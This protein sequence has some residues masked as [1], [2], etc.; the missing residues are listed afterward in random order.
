MTDRSGENSTTHAL[1]QNCLRLLPLSILVPDDNDPPGLCPA[2][3]GQTC[4]CVSCMR[5]AFD[6]ALLDPNC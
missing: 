1:C 5:A 2:C 4:N 3:G 6:L